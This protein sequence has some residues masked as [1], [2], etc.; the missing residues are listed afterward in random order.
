MDFLTSFF[1]RKSSRPELIQCRVFGRGTF[2]GANQYMS[3]KRTLIPS[4][5]NLRIYRVKEASLQELKKNLAKARRSVGHRDEVFSST[6][7]ITVIEWPF[8]PASRQANRLLECADAVNSVLRLT[9]CVNY[10]PNTVERYLED[11]KINPCEQGHLMEHLAIPYLRYARDCHEQIDAV[12]IE[13]EDGSVY[14]AITG[15]YNTA[16]LMD[17]IAYI[18]HWLGK[19]IRRGMFPTEEQLRRGIQLRI[20]TL[21]KR[22]LSS[23][24]IKQI[25]AAD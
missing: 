15:R 20:L 10:K 19:A 17:V 16:I 11:G 18:W 3:K 1:F 14:T 13:R 23:E 25:L 6:N 21:R 9:R 5:N 12:T 24:A 22:K 8:L 7:A 4:R 2:I